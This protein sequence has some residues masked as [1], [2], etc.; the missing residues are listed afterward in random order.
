MDSPI[1]DSLSYGNSILVFDCEFWH[2][3]NKADVHYL[4]EKDYFFVPRELGG[5]MCEKAKGW[6]IK[7]KFFVTLDC[8]LDDVALP[9]SQFATVKLETAAELDQIQEA[10]GVPW[11]DA[12]KSVLDSKQKALLNKAIKLYKNDPNIKKHHEPY[13]WVRKFLN[14]FA[15]STVIV[16]GTG[17]L[18]ALQ[19]LCRIKGFDYP[20]PKKLI[21]IAD[22]NATS[23]RLCGS[24]KLE[25]TFNCIQSRLSPEIRK[26]LEHLP[27][28]EAHDPTMDAT[29]TLIVAMFSASPPK[30]RGR[31]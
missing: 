31:I 12:H 3:F 25:N 28:G 5:F 9:V 20:Q 18:E 30:R 11:V 21:D 22:W 1:L 24:A 23:K 8:P 27:L 15:E 7:E 6:S 4:P 16:K 13:S 17:D 2:L 14:V 19:N 10:I 29:M 26:V